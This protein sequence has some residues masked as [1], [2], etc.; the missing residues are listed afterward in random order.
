MSVQFIARIARQGLVYDADS[1]PPT[2]SSLFRQDIVPG[3]C[4]D[5]SDP[6]ALIALPAQKGFIIGTLFHRY[7]PPERVEQLEPKEIEAICRSKGEHL[8]RRYWGRYVA[9]IRSENALSVI[10]D[11]SGA[12]PCYHTSHRRE[13]VLA[14]APSLFSAAGLP[15][16]SVD[17]A[18]VARALLI[19]GM[20]EI[21][22]ALIGV[23]QLLPGTSL[24]IAGSRT[25]TAIRWDPWEFVSSLDDRSPDELATDLR[26]TVQS[27]VSGWG[28]LYNKGLLTVSGGLDSSI[29]A[30]CLR[31]VGHDLS[32]LTLTTD[33]PLG[34]ERAF[35]RTMASYLGRPVFEER[36]SLTHID[37]NKSSVSHLPTPGGRVDAQSFDATALKVATDVGANAIFTGNGGDNVF[38]MSRSARS[39]AD[40]YS[41]NG[42]SA[43]L[44]GTLRDIRSL[45]GATALQASS[46]GIAAWRKAAKGY[47]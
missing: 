20:P 32:L 16:L 33:D 29:V 44:L 28:R 24:E 42:L 8:L 22:T 6:R 9:V 17:T 35:A 5:I 3:L 46:Q 43:G 10:R 4:L 7:G 34:D 15:S 39:L 40:R 41:V 21:T 14:S 13:L 1:V 31:N 2:I 37:L 36:Y 25:T 19:A 18:G 30:A 38:Y 47:V 27:C 11:P 45:T 23:G 26:R 12:M